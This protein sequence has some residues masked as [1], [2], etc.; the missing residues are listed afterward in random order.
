MESTLSRYAEPYEDDDQEDI[1]DDEEDFDDDYADY[2]G[3][4]NDGCMLPLYDM[5]VVGFFS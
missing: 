4:D 3:G 5:V 1:E 2:G